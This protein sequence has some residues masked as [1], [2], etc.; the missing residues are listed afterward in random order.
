MSTILSLRSEKSQKFARKI[1]FSGTSEQAP[2]WPPSCVLRD[3]ERGDGSRGRGLLRGGSMNYRTFTDSQGHRWEVWLVLPTAA[4]RRESERRVLAD[5]RTEARVQAS[6]RRVT[7]DRRRFSFR[8]V[9]VAA[10]YA[11]GWLCF[12]SEEEKRRLAPVPED[13]DQATAEKLQSWCLSAKRVVKC[14]P[15]R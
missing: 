6:E 5:R 9:G 8:R 13:W 15:V 4:E 3:Y 10:V 12:E 11:S 1:H 7:L 14:G 2:K